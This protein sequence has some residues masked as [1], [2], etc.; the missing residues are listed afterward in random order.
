MD[1]PIFPV[2]IAV[3]S[4]FAGLLL[5]WGL[6]RGRISA[7]NAVPSQPEVETELVLA[8][9]RCRSLEEDCQH[10]VASDDR[11]MQAL[12]SM[13]A[14]LEELDDEN[15]ALKRQFDLASSS[16]EAFKASPIEPTEEI[17]Q[18]PV[19]ETEVLALQTLAKNIQLEF[20]LLAELQRN[21]TLTTT[22]VQEFS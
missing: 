7:A 12:Q 13:T 18:L 3:A 2:L 10:A 21:F 17:T 19:L 20:Q 15:A 11:S 14:R 16:L 4:F 8:Q 9:A 5:G 1:S 22:T 6:T